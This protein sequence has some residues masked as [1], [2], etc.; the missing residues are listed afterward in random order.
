MFLDLVIYSV[1]IHHQRN[2][3]EIVVLGSE[4]DHLSTEI[5]LNFN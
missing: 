2:L 4:A 3:L 5:E 1:Q